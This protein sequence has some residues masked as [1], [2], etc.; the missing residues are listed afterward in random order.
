MLEK[1]LKINKPVGWNKHVCWKIPQN[2]KPVGWHK[3]LLKIN[4]PVGR[5]KHVCW[6][7]SSKLINL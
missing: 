7:N 1:F 5:N 6:K 2:N 3:Q 4:K